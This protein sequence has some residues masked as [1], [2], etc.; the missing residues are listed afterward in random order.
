MCQVVGTA[1]FQAKVLK[2]A[3]SGRKGTRRLQTAAFPAQLLKERNVREQFFLVVAYPAK[4]TDTGQQRQ[5]PT[6][7]SLAYS[8]CASLRI[9][10]NDE[11]E[12]RL[13][14]FDK[15][16]N[17]LSDGKRRVHLPQDLAGVDGSSLRMAA[18][19]YS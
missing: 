16:T 5:K 9:I 3:M 18:A 2:A 10:V 17:L 12:G 15:R 7:R 6:V 19:R 11:M 4:S 13:V 14:V 8:K 1:T